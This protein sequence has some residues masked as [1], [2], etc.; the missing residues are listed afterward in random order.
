MYPGTGQVN[1]NI[2]SKNFHRKISNTYWF[3]FFFL[4]HTLIMYQQKQDIRDRK[5]K[6][7]KSNLHGRQ[8]LIYQI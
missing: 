2:S 1:I 6:N 5:K 3:S 4:T 7:A 8:I